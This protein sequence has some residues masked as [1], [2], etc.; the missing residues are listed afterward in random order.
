[1]GLFAERFRVTSLWEENDHIT[2]FFWLYSIS[3]IFGH[4]VQHVN[5]SIFHLA[6]INIVQQTRL[7][8]DLEIETTHGHCSSLRT[9]S[10]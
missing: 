3:A 2:H 7:T 8:F 1:M 4:A 5:L 6:L 9:R 10:R